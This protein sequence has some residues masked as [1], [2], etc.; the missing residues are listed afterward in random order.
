MWIQQRLK[1]WIKNGELAISVHSKD[2]IINK[3]MKS[4]TKE[5]LNGFTSR[6]S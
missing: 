1:M 2:L 6:Y 4:N 5:N 3:Y